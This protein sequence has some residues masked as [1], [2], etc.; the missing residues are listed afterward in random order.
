MQKGMYVGGLLFIP[1]DGITF[2]LRHRKFKNDFKHIEA[3]KQCSSKSSYEY[4]LL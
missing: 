4:L 2:Y 1:A 3:L